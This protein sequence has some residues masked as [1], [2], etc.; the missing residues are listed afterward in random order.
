M[1]KKRPLKLNLNGMLSRSKIRKKSIIG[2][3][4]FCNNII[5]LFNLLEG[6]STYAGDTYECLNY[7]LAKTRLIES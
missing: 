5:L 1:V 3:E 4:I 6:T 7:K 2:T